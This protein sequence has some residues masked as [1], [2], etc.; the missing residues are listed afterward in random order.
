MQWNNVALQ[1]VHIVLVGER[2]E[3]IR[4]TADDAAYIELCSG[5]EN[6]A[7]PGGV[8][9]PDVL[10]EEVSRV[11]VVGACLNADF[12]C[13][14]HHEIIGHVLVGL[15]VVNRELKPEWLE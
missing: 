11:I 15:L 9:G 4:F 2:G 7:I 3:L 8:V 12:E 6:I 10:W 1:D 5:I 14:A 13:T